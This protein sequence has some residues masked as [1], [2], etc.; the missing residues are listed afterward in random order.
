MPALLTADAPGLNALFGTPQWGIFGDNGSEILV[1]DSVSHV[2]YARDYQ[3]SDYPQEKGA[4]ESYNKVKVPFKAR[5]GFLIAET[6]RDFLANVEAAVA[7]RN[8]VTI[9]T[10]EQSYPSANLTHY[11]FRREVRNGVTMILVDVW[12]EEV[13]VIGEAPNDTQSVNGATTTESGNVQPEPSSGTFNTLRSG[14]G[15]TEIPSGEPLAPPT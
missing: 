14:T 7:S 5:V 8:F 10:P 11:S 6:R 9:V 2:D 12:C 4:F 3:I 13:R 15:P 1:S